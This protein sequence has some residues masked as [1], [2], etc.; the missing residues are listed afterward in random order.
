MLKART[1]P[2][3]ILAGHPFMSLTTFRKHGQPVATPVWFA[4]A[5]EKLYVMTEAGT[6]KVKRIRHNA[7]VEV[8]PCSMSGDLLGESVEAMARIL[9]PDQNQTAK[10]AFNLKYGWQKRG[11]DLINRLRGKEMLYLEIT[12]M[13]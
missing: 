6:G 11:W 13:W 4:Q 12:P 9:P 7:Q 2:F 5:D 8:A 10:Q 1:T 3:E